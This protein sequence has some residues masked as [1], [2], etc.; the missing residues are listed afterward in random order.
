MNK[1]CII[2]EEQ[3]GI[4][5]QVLKTSISTIEYDIQIWSL[6]TSMK[7]S[8]PKLHNRDVR[9]I[10]EVL[11]SYGSHK[12]FV[13]TTITSPPYM[14]FEVFDLCLARANA[15]KLWFDAREFFHFS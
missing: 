14:H 9:R 5:S 15:S 3:V 8:I 12:E 1:T 13:D 7:R 2:A 10:I 4:F 6:R 11:D